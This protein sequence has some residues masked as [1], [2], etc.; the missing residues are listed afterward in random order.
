MTFAVSP[1]IRSECGAALSGMSRPPTQNFTFQDSKNYKLHDILSKENV[2][3]TYALTPLS[4][5]EK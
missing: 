5:F 2:N 3:F 1:K 4:S